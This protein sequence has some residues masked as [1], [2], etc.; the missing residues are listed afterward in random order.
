VRTA[1]FEGK[2]KDRILNITLLSAVALLVVS[3]THSTISKNTGQPTGAE[4]SDSEITPHSPKSLG[5][6]D[7][8]PLLNK[9]G[10]EIPETAMP[11]TSL[12]GA[13]RSN[14]RLPY[15]TSDGRLRL[16]DAKIVPLNDLPL[17]VLNQPL[18]ETLDQVVSPV[19]PVLDPVADTINKIL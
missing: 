8:L 17:P 14:I 4:Y 18:H 12:P 13:P 7:T 10:S 3:F 2:L 15:T 16:P 6:Y 1:L 19:T 9:N 11:L 5:V